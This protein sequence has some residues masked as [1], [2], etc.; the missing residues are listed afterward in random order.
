[1][2]RR[3]LEAAGAASP[4]VTADGPAALRVL[5]PA[6]AS[7]S[8]LTRPGKIE[9]RLV[10]ATPEAPG[11]VALPKWSG[12]GT[13]SVEPQVIVNE[14]HLRDVQ[15]REEKDANG[16]A[17]VVV[18]AFRFDPQALKNMLTATVD[19]VGRKLAIL[20]DDRVV[21]DPIIR[22]PVA[23]ASGEI[24]GDF[25]LQSANELVELLASGRL[26]ARV[27]VAAREPAACP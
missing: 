7:P 23:A 24:S 25:T 22:A 8:L 3:R 20:V 26:P 14:T 12:E 19:A 5:L 4:S 18:I 1:M 16:G 27:V 13:E 2:L 11:A 6:G 10:A 17:S 21:V 9:F 15:A